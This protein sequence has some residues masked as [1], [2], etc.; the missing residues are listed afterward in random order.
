[1][2]MNINGLGNTYN[3]INTNS[4]QYK[5]LKEKGWRIDRIGFRRAEFKKDGFYL[6]GKKIKLRGLNRHQSYQIGRASC[7]ERV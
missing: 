7:R 6:N 4:K 3:S 5:A 2:S 1:M